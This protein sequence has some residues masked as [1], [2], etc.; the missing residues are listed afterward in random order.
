VSSYF[1]TAARALATSLGNLFRRPVTV[2]FPK[3]IRPRAERYRA[4]FALLH[5][6]DG[7][8]AC[9][10]CLQC[11]RI[12]PSQVIAIKA[13]GKRESPISGKKRGYA[14]DFVLDLNACIY[15][16]LCVQVCPTDA[17]VMTREPELPAY[18]REDLVL[19]MEKLYANERS[20]NRAWGDATRLNGM[21]VPPKPPAA[22]KP[23]ATAAPGPTATAS[24]ATPAAPAP[25]A[26][27]A[28]PAPSAAA[29]TPAATPA[30]PS[31]PAPSAA[32]SP[33]APAVTASAPSTAPAS[34]VPPSSPAAPDPAPSGP[35]AS[36][37]GA[38]APATSAPPAAPTTSG[39]P[40][41]PA[42]DKTGEGTS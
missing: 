2:E 3:V 10:G 9:I 16:E 4:S 39:A 36:P 8:E 41:V 29:P 15:C 31:S 22:A 37:A 7:D 6:E 34:S 24:A 12:C 13:G 23:A 27:A 32:S 18:G 25:G 14:D 26:A 17:I 28:P 40:T 42:S 21:Q 5:E 30:S 1:A 20:K 19:T 11:E 35:S 33:P 38:G